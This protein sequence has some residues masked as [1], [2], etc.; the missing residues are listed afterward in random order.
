MTLGHF[1]YIPGMILLGIVIGYVMAGRVRT[2][3]SDV[4]AEEDQRS[5]ARRA[6]A[7]ARA[8]AA[9]DASAEDR[10]GGSPSA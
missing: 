7:R 2:A 6:R 1:I 5:A 4:K 9:T 3:S 10:P 8:S